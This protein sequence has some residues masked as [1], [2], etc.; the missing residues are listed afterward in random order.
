M[1]RARTAAALAAIALLA[2]AQVAA[3]HEGNPN[4]RSEITRVVPSVDGLDVEVLNFDD[5]LRLTNRTGEDI[6]VEGYDD[7]PYVRIQADGSVE[8]NRRS[9]AYYLNDDRFAEAEVPASADPEAAPEWEEVDGSSSYSWHDHRMHYMSTG[10]PPQV[11]DE[12][13]ETKVFDYEIPLELGG[14][15]GAIEGTLTWVGEDSD[16]PLAPFIALAVVALGAVVL[17]AVARRRRRGD[18]PREAW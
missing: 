17:V 15:P 1:R 14:K 2:A 5:S 13:E 10:T 16:F 18:P 12:S 6:V 3:A 11:E 7:E 8:V 9:P 4:Y